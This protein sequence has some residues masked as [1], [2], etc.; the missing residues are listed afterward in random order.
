VR[1][2]A[3]SL[4]ALFG[5]AI[6]PFN[7]TVIFSSVGWLFV[8]MSVAL[9]VIAYRLVR[10]TIKRAS[11]EAASVTIEVSPIT[12]AQPERHTPK[13]LESCWATA[14]AE[15]DGDARRAGLWARVFSEAHGNESVAKAAYLKARVD[16]M[17]NAPPAN[18]ASLQSKGYSVEQG[19]SRWYV[20]DPGGGIK[21]T[22]S[23]LTEIDEQMPFLLGRVS[24]A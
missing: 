10:P 17:A 2:L 20:T 12:P 11:A 18:I 21:R 16:E 4:L 6:F 14:L 24:G 15:Y 8:A 7:L 3:A 19:Q 22:F 23:S 13:S 1:Y 5:I 9:L